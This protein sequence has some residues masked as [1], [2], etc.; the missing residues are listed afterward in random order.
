MQRTRRHLVFSMAAAA[1]ATAAG[2]LIACGTG[3]AT[4]AP[5]ATK[6]P[7]LS[8]KFTLDWLIQGPQAPFIVALDKGYFAEQSLNV[9][10]D[11]GY[12]S[13]DAVVKIASGAYDMGF[14]DFNS[15]IE[16][17]VKNPGQQLMAIA[18]V[19]DA[20][21]LAVITLKRTGIKTPKDLEGKTMGEPAGGAGRRLFPLFAKAN[22]IDASTV[23][24][25]AMEPALREAV[26][27]KGEVDAIGG[28]Y[29]TSFFNLTAAGIPA[30]EIVDFSY[31]KYGVD[32]YGNAVIA[33]AGYLEG[34]AEHVK[35]FLRALAKAWRDTVSKPDEAIAILKKRDPLLDAAVERERLAIAIRQNM[36]TADVQ[37]NGFGVVRKDR[38]AR[39]IDVVAEG[40]E[41]PAKPKPEHVFTDR[42]LP[43][44]AERKPPS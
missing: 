13:S 40:F 16:F 30:S 41:L 11:R 19:Y 27:I 9:T 3:A 26:L 44:L 24:W 4:P 31:A 2:V 43:P 5:A 29:F 6:L 38:L 28:F 42:Y 36:L 34:H 10:I 15:M 33:P 20:S 8:L 37:T 17:N 18:M 21:P 25:V 35:G 23:K 39:N 12:G 14:G 1:S 32:L 7:P 22:K